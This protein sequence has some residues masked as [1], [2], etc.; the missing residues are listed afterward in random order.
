MFNT[1]DRILFADPL[2]DGAMTAGTFLEIAP[3]EPV[4]V[5]SP[6][7][8]GMGRLAD[9][10]WVRRDDGTTAQVVYEYIRLA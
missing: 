4:E 2:Q 7:G 9:T 5:P 8:D 1:G 10:A 3:N 6:T